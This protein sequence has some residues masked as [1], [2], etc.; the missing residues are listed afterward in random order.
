M[1]LF[2]KWKLARIV[3]T[4]CYLAAGWLL[5]T[6][7]VAPFPLFLGLLFSTAV[8]FLTY[9]VFIAEGEAARRAL[10]PRLHLLVLYI[11]LIVFRVYA[12]S[13]RIALRVLTG[14]ITPRI[15]HFRSRLRS[16]MARV[17]LANSITLT[18]GTVSLD[19]DEDHL[20]VHWLEARTTHS[21]YAARLIARP[22]E[23]WLRRIWV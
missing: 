23:R 7:T 9:G 8:A 19:L 5:F 21:G 11:L 22:F 20:I 14:D 4:A 2:R 18:P 6:W 1:E 3:L 17:V 16:E 10:L 13:F 15:V 12:A